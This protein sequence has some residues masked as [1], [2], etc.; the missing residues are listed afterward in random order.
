MQQCN[1]DALQESIKTSDSMIEPVTKKS[2]TNAFRHTAEREASE[3][4]IKK[5]VTPKA[6]G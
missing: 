5:L 4:A 6:A 2:R 3:C 1:T